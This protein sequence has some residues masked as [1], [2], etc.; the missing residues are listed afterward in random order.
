MERPATRSLRKAAAT[1]TPSG[2]NS[3][4]WCA[5]SLTDLIRKA[6]TLHTALLLVCSATSAVALAQSDVPMTPLQKQIHRLDLGITAV[7]IYTTK[8][9][10]PVSSAV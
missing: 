4:P 9:S 10:G 7:G 1:A 2:K 8:T 3:A 6:S 5:R